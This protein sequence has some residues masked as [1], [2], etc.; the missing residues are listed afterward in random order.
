MVGRRK[1]ERA[2]QEGTQE[3]QTTRPCSDSPLEKG[4]DALDIRLNRIFMQ[5]I[6]FTVQLKGITDGY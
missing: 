3:D 5:H 2:A 1:E 6:I 4:S